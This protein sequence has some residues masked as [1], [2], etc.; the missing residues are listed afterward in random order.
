MSTSQKIDRREYFWPVQY[1]HLA[2]HYDR[3]WWDDA[4][5]HCVP[6]KPPK[7]TQRNLSSPPLKH[8]ATTTVQPISHL[9]SHIMSSADEQEKL[10]QFRSLTGAPEQM[11]RSFLEASNWDIEVPVVW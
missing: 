5:F 3:N 9:F 6:H 4:S 10:A 11:A 2:I 8:P 1:S 7:G